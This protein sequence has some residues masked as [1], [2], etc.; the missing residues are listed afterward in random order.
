V[1]TAVAA[2]RYALVSFLVW[3]PVGLYSAPLVL[4][5]LGRGFDLTA[6]AALGIAYGITVAVLELPTGGLAD[7]LGRRTVLIAAAVANMIAFGIL[8]LA[9]TV[10]PLVL[11][12]VLR[13][14]G[15]ALSSGPAEAWFVDAAHAADGPDA[16]LTPGLAKGATASSAALAIGVIAGGGLPVLVGDLGGIV[17][18]ALPVLLGAAFE[19]VLLVVVLL[20][21]PEPPHP[22]L[23]V[24]AVAAGVPG[25]IRAGLRLG[26]RDPVLARIMI[27]MGGLGVALVSIELLTPNWLAQL[28]GDPARAGLAYGI[29]AAVGFAADGLGAAT[30]PK[31]A[32]RLGS[33]RRAASFGFAVAAVALVGLAA[34]SP[35]GGIAGIVAAGL[36]YCV[37]FFGLGVAT[38]PMGDV[39]HRRV[40]AGERATVVSVQSLTLQLVGAAGSVS[41]GW[42]AGRYGVAPS[43]VVAGALLA[44]G[45][46]ALLNT[47]REARDDRVVEPT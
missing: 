7:V 22:R 27:A 31:A 34:V 9:T 36:A 44:G 30:G 1:T 37:F 2:R 35:I 21:L 11:S 14:V 41:L 17:A 20:G 45:A 40:T 46:V 32:R 3:L 4:L 25:T 19:V 16:D 29:V 12:A 26:L 15:R 23:T 8:G 42:V 38:A 28:T 39:L 24:R 43:F 18:L 5:L 13:G 6:V 10:V 47:A 33:S